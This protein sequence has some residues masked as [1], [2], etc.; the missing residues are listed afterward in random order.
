MIDVLAG[1]GRG[2]CQQPLYDIGRHFFQKVGR[3]VGIQV[4]DDDAGLFFGQ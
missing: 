1:I 2:I 4:I 3:I